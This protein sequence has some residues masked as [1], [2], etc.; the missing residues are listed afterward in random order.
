MSHRSS[1]KLLFA[2]ILAVCAV[3]AAVIFAMYPSG[4]SAHSRQQQMPYLT[5]VSLAGAEFGPEIPNGEK[6]GKFGKEYTY[7]I[8]ELTPGYVSPKYFLGKGMN[9]FR[10]PIRWERLQH[11]LGEPLDEKEVARLL[12]TVKKLQEL[13]AWVIVDLHNYARYEETP[14]GTEKVP[15]STLADVWKRMAVHFKDSPRV[16]FGLMNEPYDIESKVWAEAANLAIAAIRETG[17]RNLIFVGGNTFSGTMHWYDHGNAETMLTIKDPLDRIVFEGHLYL[18]AGSAGQ[19][20]YCIGPQIG[21]KRVEPFLRWLKE[22]NKVGFVGEFGGGANPRC[23]TA[24]AELAALL[25]KNRD[26]ILGWAYWA[27]GPWWPDEYFSSIEPK[28]GQDAPQLKA[29]MPHIVQAAGPTI[30]PSP[31]EAN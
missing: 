2:A 14:I 1:Q 13:G 12:L 23:V 9:T 4:F 18:D 22:N 29:L 28:D 24:I 7:P 8:A 3:L 26:I 31:K 20:D 27:A 30:P 15:T 6:R 17:A 16:I 11:A 5:G 21:V 19:S 25:G 10:L